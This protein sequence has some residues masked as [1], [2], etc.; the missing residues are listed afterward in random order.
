MY[1]IDKK[2]IMTAIIVLLCILFSLYASSVAVSTAKAFHQEDIIDDIDI[3]GTFEKFK[4]SEQIDEDWD[5]VQYSER[6]F[7]KNKPKQPIKLEINE[8]NNRTDKKAS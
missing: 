6:P 2:M 8:T 1:E 7:V 3:Q 4:R 5:F